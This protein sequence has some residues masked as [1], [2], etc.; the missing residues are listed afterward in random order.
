MARRVVRRLGCANG[1]SAVVN[2]QGGTQRLMTLTGVTGL[3]WERNLNDFGE[4]HV[5]LS[6]SGTSRDCF[7]KIGQVE[8]W[9]HEVELYRDGE[10]L[11][12]GP[13][14]DVQEERT[15][16][17][18][19]ARDMLAWFSRRRIPFDTDG[20]PMAATRW[21]E[22]LV[23]A[24]FA[25]H[26]PNLLPFLRV[27]RISP[28]QPQFQ[29]WTQGRTASV[30]TE[31]TEAAKAG[32]DF[33]AIG[34]HVFVMLDRMAAGTAPYRLRESDFLGDF[35]V[36]KV[37]SE[38]ATRAT[39]VGADHPDGLAAVGE[40]GGPQP[41]YGVVDDISTAQGTT[42]YN[43][44]SGMARRVVG[45]GHPAPIVVSLPSGSQLS[46]NAA[47]SVH[48]LIPGRYLATTIAGYATRVH[49]VMKLNQVS[50]KWSPGAAEQIAVAVIPQD[51]YTVAAGPE[52]VPVGAKGEH[53]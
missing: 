22:E 13:V 15:T 27:D 25:E 1:Y 53:R 20:T 50:G 16:I 44:L 43:A 4:A 30:F 40:W 5:E 49:T 14:F 23:R 36:R 46:P 17:T 37:G 9:A 31:V 33:F 6:K 38:T 26:D 3:D 11:W 28:D 47:V 8:P 35:R 34:R 10:R 51:T 29:R 52:P 24:S 7:R 12:S 18:L 32:L 39:V 21:V 41:G 48:D 45:Y 19:T 42:D 2:H